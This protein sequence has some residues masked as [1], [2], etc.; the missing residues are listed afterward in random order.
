M[1]GIVG[2]GQMLKIQPRVNLRRADVGVT[3]QLLHSAQILARLQQM[4]GKAVAQHMRMHS[5]RQ[6]G[7]LASRFQALP[8]HDTR[9]AQAA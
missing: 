6:A 1:S 2:L 7:L 5:Q 8:D 3:K 4:A 9:H